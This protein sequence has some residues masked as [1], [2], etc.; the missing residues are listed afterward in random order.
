[1]IYRYMFVGYTKDV[2]SVKVTEHNKCYVALSSESGRPG[3]EPDIMFMYVESN[4]ETVN[5]ELLADGHMIPF[6]DGKNWQRAM[7][8]FHFSK[9][10]NQEQWRRKMEKDPLVMMMRLKPEKVSAYIFYHYQYQEEKPGDGDRYGSIYLFGNEIIFYREMP[11][12]KETEKMKGLLD[13]DLSP[14][15]RWGEVMDDFFGE[16]WRTAENRAVSDYIE[17]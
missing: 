15:D 11:M 12:E 17:F 7:D 14:L 6:P 5:P 3:T 9:P 16:E 8:I 2:H 4:E 1:M 13:T 10:L